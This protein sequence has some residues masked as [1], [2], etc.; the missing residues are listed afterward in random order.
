M[1]E[2]VVF[3]HNAHKSIPIIFES[4]EEVNKF[5]EDVNS[6]LNEL[7]YLQYVNVSTQNGTILKL[8]KTFLQNSYIEYDRE[9]ES[10]NV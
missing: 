9:K 2:I 7:S 1:K 10:G 4:Y 3:V 6:L 5:L 8:P